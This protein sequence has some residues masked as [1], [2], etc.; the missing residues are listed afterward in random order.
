MTREIGTGYRKIFVVEPSHDFS[1]LKD[2]CEQ[3]VFLT[4]GYETV[5]ILQDTIEDNLRS[6]K[7][8]P[9]LDAILPVGRVIA[10]I[11]TGI[12]LGSYWGDKTLWLG[13]YSRDKGYQFT[14]GGD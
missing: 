13:T 14:L 4:T 3:I 6:Q 8:D 11:F 5:D 7:F 9:S 2:W 12:I 1:A 10:C